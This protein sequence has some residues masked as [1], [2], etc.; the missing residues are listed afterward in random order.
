M[1]HGD[2]TNVM[3]FEPFDMFKF[4]F[5]FFFQIIVILLRYNRRIF[6][7]DFYLKD[8]EIKNETFYS[9]FF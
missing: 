1:A 9:I 3:T 8:I 7:F 4:C 2:L 5:V 6:Q